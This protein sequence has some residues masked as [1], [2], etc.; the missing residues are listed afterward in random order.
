MPAT[1]NTILYI[2]FSF[3]I[4]TFYSSWRSHISLQYSFSDLWICENHIDFEQFR[5]KMITLPPAPL[6]ENC[7]C[8]I[9]VGHILHRYCT[10]VSDVL[11][12]CCTD[13]AQILQIYWKDIA[14]LFQIYCKRPVDFTH[15]SNGQCVTFLP[16]S[17]NIAHIL[18]ILKGKLWKHLQTI[19]QIVEIFV[20]NIAHT[21]LFHKSADWTAL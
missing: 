7:N 6:L 4:S 13:I 5:L 14:Q 10:D 15:T 17:S 8:L 2:S 11:N 1:C 21:I 3:V 9:F 12:R 20:T 18:Q 19:L 16:L